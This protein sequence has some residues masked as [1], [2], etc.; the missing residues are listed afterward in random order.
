MAEEQ[1]TE[2]PARPFFLTALCFAFLV[3]SGFLTLLFLF[4]IFSNKWL[5]D[6][7]TDFLPEMIFT[8]TNVFL[9]SI[10]GFILYIISAFGV[11]LMLRMKRAGFYLYLTATLVIILVPH[12]LGFGSW[13]ATI[14]LVFITLLFMI[15]IRKLH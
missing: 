4:S 8:R 10:A 1:I 15:Y 13:L 5:T 2:N 6:V 12:F 14:I 9:F 11:I 3:Y 7:L